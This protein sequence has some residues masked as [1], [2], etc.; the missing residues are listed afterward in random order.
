MS[1]YEPKHPPFGHQ[2]DHFT[3]FRDAPFH[4][5]FWEQGTGKSKATIDNA[6]F[7]FEEGEVDALL[8]VAPNGVHLN[9]IN[10]ELPTHLPDRLVK[11]TQLLAYQSRKAQT[12]WHQQELKE[13][14]AWKGF[15]VLAMS[16]SAFNTA[17]GKKAVWQF[18]KKR[19]VF[20]VLDEAVKIAHAA[21]KRTQAVVA[22]GRYARYRRILTGTPIA[23]GAFDV[24][25]PMQFLSETFWARHGLSTY[26][27]FKQH[28][29]VWQTGERYDPATDSTREFPVLVSYRRLG[30]LQEM[31][32]PHSSR[33]LKADVLD[34]PPKLYQKV[35]F[36]P[37]PEQEKH[38]TALRD[39]MMTWIEGLGDNGLVTAPLAITRLLR[40]QQVL[41]GY[42]PTDEGKTLVALPGANPRMNTLIE[43][44]EDYPR[45]AIV[46]ARFRQD[47]NTICDRLM[48]AKK[49]F[50]RYDGSTSDKDREEARAR[51]QGKP[52][53]RPA[54][55][56]VANPAAAG[57]GLTLHAA[58][59]VVYYSNGFKL[60]ERLQSED[61]AH[62][63]GQ[64]K[65]VT[66]VDIVAPGTIDEHI[67]K[68]LRR[69]VE[70]A[71]A[72]TGDQLKEWI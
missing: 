69:K 55:F 16:Y 63:I 14:L 13:L 57:E 52:G 41:S 56:F 24:Y 20:Y 49:D 43:H 6:C 8:V 33:V 11:R 40:L 53:H 64:T 71:A 23:Q 48:K 68:N 61:R 15:S 42:L 19:R 27:E 66:Y 54:Q 35:Y 67:I 7:L 36:E 70:I 18:L 25:K 65:A 46:W 30:E 29:G 1:S 10:D 39:E 3:R 44:L 9:W 12:R 50:V 34:L 38:Y 51:F 32:A 5:V 17:A 60:T 62:R 72:V 31:L 59:L 58:D 45:Q 47:I 26:T 28:F 22:S 2:A 37:T 21:T 4:A